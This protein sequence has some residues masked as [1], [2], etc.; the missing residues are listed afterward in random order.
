MIPHDALINALRELKFQYKGQTDR[1]LLYK[2]QGGTQR[3]A[4]R[5]VGLHDEKAA[6][7]I[8]KQAGMQSEKIEKFIANY[9]SNQH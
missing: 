4:I 2:K 1:V 5:R 6:R 3:I 9:R 7:T 8:L